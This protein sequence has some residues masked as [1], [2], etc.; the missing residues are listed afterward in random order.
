MDRIERE[1]TAFF[2]FSP[3]GKPPDIKLLRWINELGVKIEE[4]KTSQY[5]QNTNQWV[6]KF[7]RKEIFTGF[8]D[9]YVEGADYVDPDGKK[10]RIFINFS[11]SNRKVVRIR[12][13]PDE[14]NLR[15]LEKTVEQYG[16]V[17]LTERE[18]NTIGTFSEVVKIRMEVM[19]DIPSFIN[20]LGLKLLVTYFGQPKSCRICNS[21]NHIA[22]TCDKKKSPNLAPPPPTPTAS[23]TPPVLT[24]PIEKNNESTAPTLTP[25]R[26]D[27]TPQ[28]SL[29]TSPQSETET[30][31][32]ENTEEGTQINEDPLALT[33][34]I[35]DSSQDLFKTKENPENEDFTLV[36]N[37]KRKPQPPIPA[38]QQNRPSREAKTKTTHKKI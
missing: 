6:I 25:Q 20:F 16:R 15:Q 18:K 27:K 37:K 17:I 2:D 35:T 23:L 21:R 1:N 11:G 8:A 3:I 29:E 34:E 24:E 38:A 7:Y 12:Y 10:H 13:V 4:L 36:P 14:V 9:K 19:E 31:V 5:Y 33:P 32:L 28:L 26:A 22:T 30:P